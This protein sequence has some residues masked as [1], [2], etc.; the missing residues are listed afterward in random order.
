MLA[1]VLLGCFTLNGAIYWMTHSSSYLCANAVGNTCICKD[2]KATPYCK[3]S[4]VA[5]DS[6][7]I[8]QKVTVNSYLMSPSCV[9]HTVTGQREIL[10]NLSPS[11]RR[12]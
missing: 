4:T 1:Q 2:G 6:F 9:M 10:P 7:A 8:N 11:F 3:T 12:R 5:C